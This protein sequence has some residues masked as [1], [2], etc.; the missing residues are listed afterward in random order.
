MI[1]IISITVMTIIITITIIMIMIM[2]TIVSHL[3]ISKPPSSLHMLWQIL[4]LPQC[5]LSSPEKKIFLKEGQ[6]IISSSHPTLQLSIL[7]S[8]KK[9]FY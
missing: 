7:Q 2:I 5:R 8:W 6:Q 1:I 4:G 3:L 9:R